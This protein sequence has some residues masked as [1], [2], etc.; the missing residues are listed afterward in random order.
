M[1]QEL[2]TYICDTVP[3]DDDILKAMDI[4]KKEHVVIKLQW[5]VTYS[6]TYNVVIAQDSTIESVREQMPKIYPI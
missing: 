6:G 5:Y 2:K 4:V 1:I 3:K